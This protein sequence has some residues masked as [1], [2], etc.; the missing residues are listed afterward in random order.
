MVVT[1]SMFSSLYSWVTLQKSPES[2]N[3]ETCGIFLTPEH[4]LRKLSQGLISF[5]LALKIKNED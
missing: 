4:S 3:S 5:F 2:E 1:V